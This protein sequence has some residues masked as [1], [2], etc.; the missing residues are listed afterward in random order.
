MR[1]II[2]GLFLTVCL[3]TPSA[4]S[5]SAELIVSAAASLT[6]AFNDIGKAFEQAH[7]GD[8]VLFNYGASDALLQQ[9]A[10]GAP[11]DIFA[12]ADQESIDKAAAQN[13]IVKD[14]RSNFVSNALVLVMPMAANLSL[15]SLPDLTGKDVRRIAVSKPETVPAGRYAKQALDT[16]G[17]WDKL[18]TK[19]I[20]TQNVRQSLD[21]VSRAEVDAGFVYRTDAMLMSDK[22]KVAFEI[23]LEK[24][25]LY[26]ITI[27]KDSRQQ[28]SAGEFIAFVQ[29]EAGQKI[30]EPYGFAKP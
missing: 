10:K 21:Y 2:F 27:I 11:A 24:S 5:Q 22:V 29:S 25:I 3:F 16:Q 28:E 23:P 17:L 8:K 26:P 4:Y 14:S 15:T 1:G 18:A 9:I 12:T 20:Y 6:N 19:F 30:L 13:L 7:P